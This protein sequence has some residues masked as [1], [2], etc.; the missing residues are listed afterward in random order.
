MPV[1]DAASSMGYVI[2]GLTD[3]TGSPVVP[4]LIHPL[5][6]PVAT[7]LLYDTHAVALMTLSLLV[8]AIVDA[9]PA[10]AEPA[11]EGFEARASIHHYFLKS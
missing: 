11:M 10:L 8:E 3:Q 9:D 6:A 2:E 7:T 1:I 4:Y 5:L